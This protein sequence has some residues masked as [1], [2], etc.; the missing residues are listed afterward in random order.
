MTLFLF[1]CMAYERR[2]VKSISAAG[3][4]FSA[5]NTISRATEKYRIFPIKR[6]Q[7]FEECNSKQT[8]LE[9]WPKNEVWHLKNL[10]SVKVN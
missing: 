1:L 4:Y 7:T 3:A 9:N 6:S 5:M 8:L 10:F 2:F